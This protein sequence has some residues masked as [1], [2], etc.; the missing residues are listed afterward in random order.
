[1]SHDPADPRALPYLP[2]VDPAASGSGAGVAVTPDAFAGFL[3]DGDEE[4][5]RWALSQQ[6]AERP[7]ALVYD[8]FVREA[9]RLVGE[10]WSSGRWTISEEHLASRTLGRVLAS[11]APEPSPAARVDPVAVLAGVA[12][13]EHAIGLMALS[14]VLGEAGLSVHDLGPD[15]PADDLARY[16]SKVEGRLVAL[17]ASSSARLDEL[18][19]TVAALHALPS[20][21]VVIVGGRITEHADLSPVGADFVGASLVD[22]ARYARELARGGRLSDPS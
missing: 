4:I 13:E 2:P 21:P 6:L 9:M 11:V 15:V 16:V 8:T 18:V 20:H 12:G 19:D 3:A 10:R 14:H 7:R 1:V 5:A 22:C 17:S